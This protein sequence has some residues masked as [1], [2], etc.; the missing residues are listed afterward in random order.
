MPV[1]M[2]EG[3]FEELGSLAPSRPPVPGA[4][5]TVSVTITGGPSGDGAFH[6]TY[7]DGI[8]GEGG[9][10]VAPDGDLTLTIPSG[11]A[12]AVAAGEVE[13]SVAYM[14]GVLKAMG[15]GALL[16]GLLASTCTEPYREWRR[17]AESL[18]GATT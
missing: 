3:W 17:R 15:D 14:R 4:N 10:G 8:P 9:A 11:D 6:W 5:G 7:V 18:L 12:R 1:W 16:L 13:P 2:G